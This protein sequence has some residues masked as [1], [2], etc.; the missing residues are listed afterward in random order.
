MCFVVLEQVNISP[1][2]PMP[3]ELR[4]I[5]WHAKKVKA[6]DEVSTK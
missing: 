2:P 6:M 5:L 4:V 3:F 1:P